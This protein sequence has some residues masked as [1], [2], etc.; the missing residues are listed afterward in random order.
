MDPLRDRFL[1]QLPAIYTYLRHIHSQNVRDTREFVCNRVDVS[2][3]I[4]YQTRWLIMIVPLQ[5]AIWGV[6]I[7]HSSA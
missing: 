4:I 3:S 7:Y 2:A 6:N 1:N 5:V